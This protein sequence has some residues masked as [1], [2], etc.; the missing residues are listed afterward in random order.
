[1]ALEVK[2]T[3]ISFVLLFSYSIGESIVEK[4]EPEEENV[5]DMSTG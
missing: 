1:M 2:N 3:V 4:M 5:F